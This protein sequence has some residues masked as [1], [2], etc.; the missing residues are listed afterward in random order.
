MIAS[1]IFERRETFQKKTKTAVAMDVYGDKENFAQNGTLK[2]DAYVTQLRMALDEAR[3]ELA[4]RDA[5]L[6][7]SEEALQDMYEASDHKA[8]QVD[9][10]FTNYMAQ[11]EELSQQNHSLQQ[12]L[13][14]KDSSLAAM[15]DLEAEFARI[16][17]DNAT[18]KK[19]CHD[20]QRRAD[21]AEHDVQ[22]LKDT[23]QQAVEERDLRLEQAADR[24]AQ[25]EKDN[26]RLQVVTPL[27]FLLGRG[28]LF[29]QPL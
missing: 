20:A 4:D 7:R 5:R 17:D 24:I 9:L 29:R 19:T 16:E 21:R 22:R 15:Q 13:R 6:Q 8:A 23:M 27:C 18:T 10:A 3:H 1:L 25:L 28:F 11:M 26:A 14:A 12:E 2:D